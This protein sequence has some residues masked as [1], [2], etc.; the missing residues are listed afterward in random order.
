MGIACKMDPR[1]T[2]GSTRKDSEALVAGPE[3]M[4][5]PTGWQRANVLAAVQHLRGILERT[6]D[7]AKARVIYE[8]L[9]DVLEPPRR[10]VRQQ[11]EMATAA[12][13]AVTIRERRSG[14]ERRLRDRRKASLT[15]RGAA[16]LRR[17]DRRSGRDRRRR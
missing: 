12:T 15:R 17:G 1:V 5:A 13:A 8:G 7:D 10:A 9:L 4:K 3:S 16:D 6:P 11:K 2:Q 14:R